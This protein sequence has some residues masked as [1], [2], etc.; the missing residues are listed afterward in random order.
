VALRE[1]TLQQQAEEL[2]IVV[3]GHQF[4]GKLDEEY[5][6]LEMPQYAYIP[7]I[8][9]SATQDQLFSVFSQAFEKIQES[10]DEWAIVVARNAEHKTLAIGVKRRFKPAHSQHHWAFFAFD[11]SIVRSY[12]LLRNRMNLVLANAIDKYYLIDI[13]APL[14]TLRVT[15]DVLKSD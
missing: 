7:N 11:D 15:N 8:S 4:V 2:E 14:R 6:S 13:L 9:V 1:V 10:P 5:A 3:I 12:D